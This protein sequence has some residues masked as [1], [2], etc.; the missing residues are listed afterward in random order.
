MTMK[1]KLFRLFAALSLILTA[2]TA[3]A[4][5]F[6][7]KNSDGV[8]IYYDIT[9]SEDLTCEVTYKDG[10]EYEGAV[11]IPS[12]V[13]YGGKTYS[14]SSIGDYAFDH[15]DGLTS[16]T[17]P[18]SVTSVGTWGVFY[19]CSNLQEINVAEDNP[20]F[21]SVDGVLFNKDK[22]YLIRYPNN[23]KQTE[24]IVPSTVTSIRDAA[25]LSSS[26]LTSLTIPN[27]VAEF[28]LFESFWGC[29]ALQEINVADGNTLFSSV[30]G[31][32]FS[33]DKTSLYVFP[34]NHKQTE[35]TVQSYVTNIEYEA[36]VDCQKLTSLTIPN[37]VTRVETDAFY[38]CSGLTSVIIPN[39]VTSI[40][41]YV[42]YD[43]S[44]LT[45]VIIPNS[46]TKI[47]GSVFEG[48]SALT[49][50]NIPNS[51]KYI[52]TGAFSGCSALTSIT[53]PE[54][55]MSVGRGSFRYCDGLKEILLMSPT[56]PDFWVDTEDVDAPIYTC[57]L[58]VPEGS[59]NAYKN[60]KGWKEFTN[61]VGINPAAIDA[62]ATDADSDI[63]APAYNMQ[64]V[65][66]NSNYKGLVIRN[67]KKFLNR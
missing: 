15:G 26:K 53:I 52:G 60:A 44:G 42:F 21:S 61:I 66:V 67:G 8:T 3:S 16:V 62:A 25:F 64:G 50:L 35:Y 9:S 37:S 63:N 41:D 65:K 55:V 11:A 59:V 38:H 19:F 23:H 58:K 12:S 20:A 46:V 33:K 29:S 45:S 51:V 39:S 40:G 5:D 10:S 6:E 49:S 43:C 31:V 34:A 4:Y 27:S 14:V 22:T 30:D 18:N 47:G 48:C 7:A 54:N 36:F 24:Y 28:D 17:I 13:S 1:T 56:P 32:L 2:Q 57:V